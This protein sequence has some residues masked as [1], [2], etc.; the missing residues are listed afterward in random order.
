MNTHLF[1]TLLQ[2]SHTSWPYV[3]QPKGVL[4]GY[5]IRGT[6]SGQRTSIALMLTQRA[7]QPI[8]RNAPIM[9]K[10]QYLLRQISLLIDR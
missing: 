10:L 9:H 4:K 8:E 2:T 1:Q 3:C 5:N 7:G 6:A